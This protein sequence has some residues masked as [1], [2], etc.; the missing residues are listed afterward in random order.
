MG[1]YPET[2][3]F[4]LDAS[5]NVQCIM[6]RDRLFHSSQSDNLKLNGII[7]TTLI[8]MC[9]DAKRVIGSRSGEMFAGKHS[10]I[11]IKEIAKTYPHIKFIV[12]TNGLLCDQKNCD[13]L[14][15][16]GRIENI[17]VSL[18][19]VTKETYNKIVKHSDFDRIIKN[20]EWIAEMKKQGDIRYFTLVMVVLS[21]NY[22][23]MANFAEMA[24]KYGAEITFTQYFPSWN[25]DEMDISKEFHPAYN[26]FVRIVNKLLKDPRMKESYF[27]TGFRD[28]KPIGTAKWLKYR[29]KALLPQLKKHHNAN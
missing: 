16:T 10:R 1:K 29:F 7:D 28:L 23:E 18:H 26:K 14:G 8:P 22:K 11:L 25:T 20:I 2:V 12:H 5:C 21:M 13:D 6:C 19:A 3:N 9:K 27:A 15:I 17:V 4:G 24:F